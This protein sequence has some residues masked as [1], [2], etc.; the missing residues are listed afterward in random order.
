M[1]L[2]LSDFF[3]GIYTRLESENQRKE[4]LDAYF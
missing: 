3:R 2:I 1:N 4:K